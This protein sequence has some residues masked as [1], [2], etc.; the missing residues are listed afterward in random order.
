[1]GVAVAVE[2]KKLWLMVLYPIFSL[3]NKTSTLAV[4][5]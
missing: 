5:S 2:G 1:L 3:A 4:N